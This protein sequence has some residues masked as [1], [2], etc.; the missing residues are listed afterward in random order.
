M[1]PV[2]I[3]TEI[4]FRQ[5]KRLSTKMSQLF[6]LNRQLYQV[7]FKLQSRLILIP[8]SCKLEQQRSNSNNSNFVHLH[9]KATWQCPM[10]FSHHSPHTQTLT[11]IFQ[12]HR[13]TLLVTM[14]R[15]QTLKITLLTMK[16]HMRR[17]AR[18]TIEEERC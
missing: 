17:D 16:S 8:Q 7:P 14:Q 6:L 3:S 15:L 10:N 1:T 9:F 12:H 11:H 5:K 13:L 18:G 2:C 4:C